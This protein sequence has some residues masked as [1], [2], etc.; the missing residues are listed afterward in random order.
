MEDF[1]IDLAMEYSNEY[2][3]EEQLISVTPEVYETMRRLQQKNDNHRKERARHY[4][5]YYFDD[6]DTNYKL[7]QLLAI[8]ISKNYIYRQ[9]VIE[10]VNESLAILKT[11]DFKLW[12]MLVLYYKFSFTQIE[13]AEKMNISQRAVS[14]RIEKALSKLKEVYLNLM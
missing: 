12:A 6:I 1:I 2:L 8:E 5:F 7:E 10:S 14:K 4:S 9:I 11:I 13:I 3:G